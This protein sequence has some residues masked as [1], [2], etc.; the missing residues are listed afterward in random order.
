MAQKIDE[1]KTFCDE[2]NAISGMDCL[3]FVLD[4]GMPAC[5][6]YDTDYTTAQYMEPFDWVDP[7]RSAGTMMGCFRLT[8]PSSPGAM[9]GDD[10]VFTGAD[11]VE[12]EVLGE[13]GAAFNLISSPALS[14]TTGTR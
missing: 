10:P 4:T 2:R 5:Y 6:A 14:L 9:A 1:C 13:V 3:T 7:V 8:P 12:Y 11:G